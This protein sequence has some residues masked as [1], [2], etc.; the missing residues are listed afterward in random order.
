MTRNT[1]E[2][3]PEESAINTE[4]TSLDLPELPGEWEWSTVN[5]IG[6]THKVNL[7]F[8]LESGKTGG[9]LGEIDNYIKNGEEAWTLHIRPIV[10]IPKSDRN[11]PR[12]EAETTEEHD[13]LDSA[14]KAVPSHIA[15]HYEL[16]FDS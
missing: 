5:H 2:D 12:S 6:M 8:G 11:R 4:D 1:K 14:I 13:S 3:I 16:T 7:Y 15:T 10:D 9:H